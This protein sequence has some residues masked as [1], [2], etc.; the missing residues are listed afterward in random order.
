[1]RRR[2][3]LGA[4]AALAASRLLPRPA[5]ARFDDIQRPIRHRHASL[6]S[7]GR[8]VVGVDYGVGPPVTVMA[9]V[10]RTG[11]VLCLYPA[12][13]RYRAAIDDEP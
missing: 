12:S 9:V 8:V 6:E 1:M 3:F 13:V 11:G 4:L 7:D 2:Q 10:C 5:P